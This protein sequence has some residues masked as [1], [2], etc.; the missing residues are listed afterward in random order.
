MTKTNDSFFFSPL[1]V[2]G[3]LQSKFTSAGG[4]F[5]QLPELPFGGSPQKL[6]KSAVPEASWPSLGTSIVLPPPAPELMP[7]TVG[8]RRLCGPVPLEN[9]VTVGKGRLL[10]DAA[11]YMGRSFRVGWGPNWTLVH[12]GNQLSTPAESKD[13]NKDAM[14]FGF[15]PRPSKNRQ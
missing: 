7:R 12:C 9:S 13:Q 5:S 1:E 8:A 3:L 14:G 10:M 4:L 6:S 15:L 11:L 2:G